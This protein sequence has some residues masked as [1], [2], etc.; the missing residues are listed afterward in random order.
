MG[1][2]KG[3]LD[4]VARLRGALR[5]LSLSKRR[6]IIA[7]IIFI[8]L[9]AVLAIEIT[10]FTLFL[11]RGRPSPRSVLSPDSGDVVLKKGELVTGEKVRILEELGL[12][13]SIVSPFG[14]L[15]A[16]M[17][18]LILLAAVAMYLAR[19][20]RTFYDSP[21]LLLLLGSIFVTYAVVAKLLAVASWSWSP[22]WGYL[23]PTA[24][25]GIIVAVLFDSGTA[26]VAVAICALLT[27]AAT[28]GSYQLV[29]FSF[30]G[31]FF[32]SLYAARTSTRHELRRVG[33]YTAFWVALVAFAVTGLS[34]RRHDL[35]V[36]AGIGFMNG[37]VSAVLA[38]G[39]L[40]FLETTFRVTTHTWL[41]DLASPEQEL[42]KD[43]ATKAPG[44]YSHSVMVANLSEAAAREI[45]SDP[46]L[47]RVTSYY[48]DI[49]KTKRP[50]F[51]VENQSYDFNPHSDLTAN[52]STLIIVSHVKDGVEMLQSNHF[53]PDLVEI[54]SQHHGT[55]IVR[56]FYEKALDEE[57]GRVDES[58][59]RYHLSKPHR[60]TAG[61][62]MLADSVEATARTLQKPSASLIEQT[63]NR[64]VDAKISD[65]QLEEC[66]LTNDDLSKIKKAFTRILVSTYHLRVDYPA[67]RAGAGAV[68]NKSDSA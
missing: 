6:A 61:I 29:A 30:L 43:L 8:L 9:G 37:T 5:R 32:P 4:R 57:T 66:E 42:L 36:N 34:Q 19:F 56:Y 28:N 53:P 20:R 11:E 39:A 62:L 60:R 15:Y 54:I 2:Y 51:F 22:F 48:H 38:M 25:V 10:P 24:A 55:S 14:V 47:A 18:A 16:F 41:L 40:P 58:T 59:F 13:R 67:G 35:L 33:L 7:S 65:G 46:L 45:G 31:G 52:L 1:L 17:F 68:D 12:K 23:M 26:L 27:G 50:Q 21:G 3:Y 49:G 63:V 64:I 44:T